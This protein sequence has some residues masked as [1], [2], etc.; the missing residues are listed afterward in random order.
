M[1]K[2]LNQQGNKAVDPI[3]SPS[4]TQEFGIKATHPIDQ[5]YES[6]SPIYMLVYKLNKTF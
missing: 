1:K 6:F 3:V 5:H 2:N 4:K